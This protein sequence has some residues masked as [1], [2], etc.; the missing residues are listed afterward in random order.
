M[1]WTLALVRLAGAIDGDFLDGDFL[2][3]RFSSVC[4]SGAGQPPLATRLAAGLL[5]LEHKHDLW[6]EALCARW[7]ENPYCQFFC[8]EESFQHQ[9]PF[10]RSSLTRWRQQLGEEQ[11]AALLQESLSAAD[12]TGALASQD[13]E[14]VVVDT[15][16]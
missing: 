14:R 2:D 7:L 5:I 6:D 1:T 12:K 9:L 3:G 13:R 8:G 10:E 15:I 16:A 4:R 11:M